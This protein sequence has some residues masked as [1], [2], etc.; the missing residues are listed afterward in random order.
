MR[1]DFRYALR[2]LAKSPGFVLVAAL[3]LGLAL[4]LNTTTFAILDAML[5]PSLPVKDPGRLFQVAMWGYGPGKGAP[6]SEKLAVLRSGTFYEDLATFTPGE[7][8][9]VRG[10]DHVE[11]VGLARVSRNLFPML[12][13][14]PE[15]GRVIERGSPDNVALVSHEEWEHMFG[16]RSLDGLTVWVGE[17]AYQ[18]IGVL[19]PDM[20]LPSHWKVDVWIPAPLAAASGWHR[21]IVI[22]KL[23]R[24]WRSCGLS[25]EGASGTSPRSSLNAHKCPQDALW[26]SPGVSIEASATLLAAST[27]DTGLPRH[28][29]SP[30]ER[31]WQLRLSQPQTRSPPPGPSGP[32]R[33]RTPPA[34]LRSAT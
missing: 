8:A 34:G 20:E 25:D 7:L 15:L 11:E 17:R 26:A 18:V 32:V 27:R 14:Q 12:G 16:G 23:K 9:T 2:S 30:A 5:H 28:R 13:V 3:C 1:R 21:P 22:V 4:A 33:R 6:L 10:A 19:P 31:Q 24:G 29:S